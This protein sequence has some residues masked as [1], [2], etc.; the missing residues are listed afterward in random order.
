[1][2]SIGSTPAETQPQKS[3]LQ[4]QSFLNI[5]TNKKEL[6]ICQMPYLNKYESVFLALIKI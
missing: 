1:M 2:F 4:G 5:S 3:N 6:F